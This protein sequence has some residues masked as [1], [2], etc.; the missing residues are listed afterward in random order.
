MKGSIHLEYND[1]KH[2]KITNSKYIKQTLTGY[3]KNFCNSITKD[4]NSP[5]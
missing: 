4:K 2:A 5:I 3:I 1:Y